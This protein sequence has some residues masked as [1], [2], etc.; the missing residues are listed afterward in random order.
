MQ[1]I[2]SK[3]SCVTLNQLDNWSYHMSYK[4]Q[5][6]LINNYD[7]IAFMCTGV[8]F[9]LS[10][11]VYDDDDD[12]NNN[13]NNNNDNIQVSCALILRRPLMCNLLRMSS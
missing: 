12:N 7:H 5:A 6:M 4:K 11:T 13:N 1:A 2:R 3:L 9:S 8:T 10:L